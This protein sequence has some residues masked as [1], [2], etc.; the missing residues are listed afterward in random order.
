M[1][2]RSEKNFQ[3]AKKCFQQ[4]AKIEEDNQKI[5]RDLL[6]LELHVRDYSNGVTSITKL[7]QKQARNKVYSTCYLIINHLNGN[8]DIAE[9]FIDQ[10]RDFL[11]NKMSRVEENELYIYESIL[12]K[13]NGKYDLAIKVLQDNDKSIVDKTCKLELLAE[14]Y[15]QTN[16]QEKALDCYEQLLKRNP[17]CKKYYYGAFKAHGIN[18]DSIDEAAEDKVTEYL[19]KKIE[20]HPKLLF[21]KRFL[22]NFLVREESFRTNFESYCKFILEKG[23]PSLVN[24]IEQMITQNEMKFN[25]T[26]STFEKFLESVQKDLTIDGQEVDPLQESFLLFFLS[27]SHFIS[28]DYLKAKELVEQS[29]EHTPTFI[30]AWQFK[31]KV[32][33]GLADKSAAE[34]SFEEAK[35]LDTAD[36]FLNA[37]CAKY[38]I[39]NNHPDKANEIMKRWSVDSNTD[40]ISSFDFQNVWY[41]VEHGFAHYE[42]GRYLEAFQM[43]N[44]LEKHLVTMYQD[45]F[46]FHFYALRKFMLRTYLD[47]NKMQDSLRR[48]TYFQQGMVGMLKVLNKFYGKLTKGSEEEK[49]N[50]KKWLQ[51]EAF[52]H[53]DVEPEKNSWE[54]FEAPHD[55]IDK[56]SDPT[57]AKALKKMVDGDIVNEAV[58]KC[59]EN[60]L[61]V[62]DNPKIHYHAIKWFLR[63]KKYD[64]AIRCV[65]YLNEKHSSWVKT[66]YITVY[67]RQQVEKEEVKVSLKEKQKTTIDNAIDELFGG[68]DTKSYFESQTRDKNPHSISYQ[69]YYIKGLVKHFNESITK[70]HTKNVAQALDKAISTPEFK[71]EVLKDVRDM[72][73][74][75]DYLPEE[76]ETQLTEMADQVFWKFKENQL[77][78]TTE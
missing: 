62:P 42:Y 58:K 60:L 75:L 78:S 30:E 17:S 13:D 7:M 52:K 45:F 22:L 68:K 50:F 10:N 54:E 51:E 26:K 67:F 41:E 9:S 24:D 34:E 35:N 72:T 28:G 33:Y 46:D 3:D 12:F 1:I 71:K 43:F 31:A 16:E 29:I 56:I 55:P 59:I 18:I 44:Y 65:K 74:L 6:A 63:G 64:Q 69:R 70:D 38:C 32:L 2:D 40:L 14:L 15:V 57:C 66:H 48:N 19:N 47:I 53:K 4:S 39:R 73:K 21:L 49:E 61:Y 27:Q 8:Y 25:V 76:L 11:L 5:T 23:V 36:R 77:P 37:E 20:D